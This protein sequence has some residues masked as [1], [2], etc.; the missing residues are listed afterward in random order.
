MADNATATV[1]LNT[2]D[3]IGEISPLLFGGFAEHMGRCIY[4]GIYDPDSPLSD[5]RGFRTDVL[6]A[7]RE[8]NLSILRYPGGNFVSGYNWRDGVG[9]RQDR[10]RRRELAWQSIETN[11]FGT[12][13]FID[14][15]R[16][17][18]VEPMMA[19]NLG[20]GSLSEVSALVEYCNAPV[21]TEHA[22]L[23]LSHGYAKPH[24]IKYWCLGNEMD[25]PW[26]IGALSAEDY[27]K[28][29]R[30]A[31]K[32]M[33]WH[34]PRIKTILCGSSGPS[35]PT[36]PA[37]DR[38]ALLNC[39]DHTDYLSLHNYAGNWKNDTP[40]YLGYA[41]EFDAQ[42]NQ[43]RTVVSEVKQK[44]SS[45]R[46][47]HLC[48]DEWNVWYKDR[49]G[50]GG[51]QEAP[52]L[53]EEVYNLED[54]LVVAQWLN[55][56][57]RH[58]DVL[59]IACIA[60]IVNVISPLLTTPTKLLKQSTFFPFVMY[61]HLASG[62][63]LRTQISAPHYRTERFGEVPVIDAAGTYNPG[64][65]NAA[66]FLIHRSTAQ[67]YPVEVKWEGSTSMTVTS[68]QQLAGTDPKAANSFERPDVLV[69][70]QLALPK[71]VAGTVQLKLPPLSLTVM[72]LTLVCN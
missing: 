56:F 50:A 23:R 8:M 34:D 7:L 46:D 53:C 52:H 16:E 21:G 6:A 33:K 49:K 69:P 1:R 36:F 29:A 63:S 42:I 57:L 27:A 25:G 31:A 51:W 22:D 17:L 14:F 13:D 32:I 11:Q 65:G 35:M 15:C 58:C 47:V 62:Q 9:P 61:S 28:K 54:A 45:T 37:W 41:T 5:D 71:V 26:Q 64:T 48:W 66:V 30:E 70:K 4:G 39:W 12:N 72:R 67:S 18:N 3:V 40:D 60:Q 24:D 10:P 2:E 43:L 38:T 68:V 59:K 44:L 19:V 20:T 55:T